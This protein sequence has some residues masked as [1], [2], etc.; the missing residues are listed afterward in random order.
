ML[1]TP[2]NS[3][4]P[5]PWDRALAACKN[6]VIVT[7]PRLPDNPIIYVNA[8]FER[9][10]GYSADEVL[11]KNCRFLNNG[12]TQQPALV[13]LRQAIHE[14][15]EFA[16]MVQNFRKDGTLFWN[17][18]SISPVF[19]EN[20]V[21]SHF[22]GIATDI[23]ERVTMEAELL[24]ASQIL[25]SVVENIPDM[26]FMKEA[27]SLRYELLNQASE[28]MLA[29][30]RKDVLGKVDT[31]IF[32]P[33]QAE[34]F[35]RD[36]RQ[37]LDSC[38]MMDI[39][40]EEADFPGRGRRILR[41]KKV[42]ILAEN[43]KPTHILGISEDV[44]A[45]REAEEALKLAYSQLEAEVENRTYELRV[46]NEALR[47]DIILRIQAEQSL[48][49][50][51]EYLKTVISNLPVVLFALDKEGRFTLSEGKALASLGLQPGQV[52]GASVFDL[53]QDHPAIMESARRALSGV[54]FTTTDEVSDVCFE[55]RWVSLRNKQGEPDGTMGISIDIT[56]RVQAETARWRSEAKFRRIFE[57]N[58]IGIVFSDVH[59]EILEANGA[60][61]EMIG[62]TMQ[63]IRSFGIDWM[64]LTPEEHLAASYN[65][66]KEIQE[67]GIMTPMEK[68]YFRK[69]GSRVPVLMGGAVLDV[70]TPTQ[71]VVFVLDIT[72]RKEAE[73]LLQQSY[74]EL[75]KR[76]AER[77][78]ELTAMNAKLLE[79]A[80]IKSRFVST[81][82]HD[83]R[84][85]L[86]AQQRVLTTLQEESGI[87]E[88]EALV[89]LIQGF[90]KNNASLLDM[91]NN[92][93]QTYQLEEG[94]VRVLPARCN[95]RD[96]AASCFTE[97]DE[98]ARQKD[99]ECQNHLP[100]DLTLEVDPQLMKRVF[101][102]LIGNALANIPEGAWIRVSANMNQ[103]HVAIM[104]QD[105]GPGIPAEIKPYVFD[106]YFAGHS[107]RQKIG[108]GLGLSICKM[109]VE[110]HGGSIHIDPEIVTGTSMR[111]QLPL[112]ALILNESGIA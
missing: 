67:F 105:N 100:E 102:N 91:I 66:A 12:N 57:S 109:I 40:E 61:L 93:L 14:A 41:T 77:T 30:S 2:P 64:K 3:S 29:L 28:E 104:V 34:A 74:E 68:E 51:Q 54:E 71:S 56:D 106:H 5:F 80:Q 107:T 88:D 52:V 47:E 111:I 31:D 21:L 112:K 110:L 59:G 58:V 65:A 85:P 84:T 17:E 36:D 83:L 4:T 82:T 9:M 53:Y 72:Q 37:V 46:A 26:I 25:N 6:A 7:D 79:S 101:R 98:L 95:M 96:L 92:L 78:S 11:G 22:I 18:L 90:L 10:T 73:K 44:T 42:P 87:R 13:E 62:Y 89:G 70:A 50:A 35:T 49:E 43:G 8:S 24:K 33:Q 38:Q 86:I 63:E 60:F 81:L 32:P 75:E 48:R 97:L 39:S 1:Y 99:I 76:V 16:G 45:L 94:L 27:K 23:T 20:D 108:S 103:D 55:T 69:D 19:D 15:R